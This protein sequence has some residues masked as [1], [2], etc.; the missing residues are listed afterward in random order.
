MGRTDTSAGETTDAS[1]L[2]RAVDDP[3]A[4]EDLYRRY[5][6]RIA[7]FAARRCTSAD[8]VADV[9]AETFDRLLRSADRYDP[10][11]APVASFVFAVAAGAVADHHRRGARQRRLADRLQGRD[12]LDDDDTARIEAALDAALAVA[13]LAPVLDAL[14]SD[15]SDVLHLVAGGM[16]PSEAARELGISPN[17]ARVRLSRVRGKVRAQATSPSTTPTSP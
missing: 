3:V 7:G 1:L 5:V 13:A 15:Q 9:V 6:R 12:L 14:P 4:L 10:E 8:D 11:R 17:A 2:A 16:S